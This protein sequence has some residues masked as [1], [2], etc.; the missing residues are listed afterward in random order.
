MFTQENLEELLAFDA[1][2]DQVVSLY[3]NA[4][5][6]ANPMETIKLQVR[7]LLKEVPSQDDVERIEQYFDLVHDW[8]KPGVALFSC[9]AHDFFRA[10]QTAVPFRNR[11]RI[12]NKPYVKPLLHLTKYYANYGVILI[13]RVGARFFD[14]HLGELQETASTEGEDVRKLKHGLGSSATGRRGGQG[15]A[16]QEDEQAQRNMRDA[17]EAAARFFARKNI[18]RLFIGGTNE[19]VAQFREMLPRQLQSCIAG[20]FPM[21]MEASEQEVRKRSLELLHELNAE[22]EERLVEQMLTNAA[23]GGAAVTGLGPTL[24]MISDGRVDTLLVSD[25]FRQ[26]GFRHTASGYL[27]QTADDDL[28]GEGDFESVPD[29][30]DEAV[31][32]TIEQGGHVEVISDN[33]ELE[34]AGRIGALLRY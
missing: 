28:F 18:R 6:S 33:A 3:I 7:G 34:G 27:T 4:D 25:G 24:R 9:S 29:V 30:V 10:Y 31:T 14:F 5:P 17:A 13:D 12:R 2:D 1:G 26:P 23:R 8:G 32:R 11:I 22:R 21:D 16:R 19:N 15:G 20:V